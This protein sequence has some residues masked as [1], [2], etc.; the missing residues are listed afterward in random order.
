MES[1]QQFGILE[2]VGLC[3]KEEKDRETV[4]CEQGSIY[5]AYVNSK[6]IG[7]SRVRVTLS[8]KKNKGTR[9]VNNWSKLL[10]K[11]QR[12][13]PDSANMNAQRTCSKL[14]G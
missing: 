3:E 4:E 7:D 8:K 2:N 9:Y 12:H 5:D 1:V 14:H 6:N 11:T 13:Q 10:H